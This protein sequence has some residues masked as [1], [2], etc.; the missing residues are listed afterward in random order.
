MFMDYTARRAQWRQSSA[1]A[2][3][4]IAGVFAFATVI[5]LFG[6]SSAAHAATY[7]SSLDAAALATML[8]APQLTLPAPLFGREALLALM[9]LGLVG[10]S[11]GAFAFWRGLSA[12]WQNAPVRRTR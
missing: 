12:D 4:A 5:A 8:A 3:A 9:S 2:F 10:M 7:T 6:L 1:K 11:A